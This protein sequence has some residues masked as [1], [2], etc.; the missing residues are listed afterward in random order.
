M[1]ARRSSVEYLGKSGF[2]SEHWSNVGSAP[3]VDAEIM[4]FAADHDYVVLTND[5]DFSAI[6]AVTHRRK[7]SVLQIR[8]RNLDAEFIGA[9]V[10]QALLRLGG[11]LRAGALLTVD[12]ATTRVRLLPLLRDE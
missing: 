3:A 2:H 1:P 9:S 7:P 8:S 6:L 12:E 11:E 10:V 4:A 5:L